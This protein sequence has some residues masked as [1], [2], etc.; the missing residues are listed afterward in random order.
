MS[1]TGIIA[2]FNPL[3]TGHKFLIDKAKQDGAVVCA[4][5]GNF[6][7]RGDT[8]IAEK[9][10]R[11]QAALLSGADLVLEIPVCYSMST[12][13]NFA[14]GGVSA[15]SAVGCD[16]LIFGSE[17]GEI[18]PL[19]AASDILETSEF[20]EKLQDYLKD[21]VTFA[22]ARQAAAEF[23]GAKSGILRGAN[24]NLAVE[25][26]SAAKK[27]GAEFEFKT[28]KRQGVLHDSD[29]ADENYASASLL[30]EKLRQGDRQFCLK[31]IPE[32]IIG[33]FGEENLS[34][35]KRIENAVLAVLKTKTPEE[36]KRLPDLSEGVENKLYT[37]IKRATSLE[38]LYSGIKVK[39]YTM[40][41]IRRLVLSAFLGVD[42]SFFMQSLP[43]VRVLGFNKTGEEI[44][45]QNAKNSK[46]PIVLRAGEI[47]SFGS[48]AQ[49]MFELESR[50]TDL[51]SLSLRKPIESGLEYTSKI[52]KDFY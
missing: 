11:A 13:Q 35:I 16:A 44:I 9:R 17:C 24:N 32:N 52:I 12:A 19:K 23:C 37:A 8:A 46:I 49:K 14:L 30:R 45:R 31:Y 7:Q 1:R 51:Y 48:S 25:Y 36:L 42:N 20:S 15:L 40:A 38:E 5:S 2:E 43:Y 18:A 3:H 4:V 39:R 29:E 26:I 6:V 33:L 47:S 27:I 21:G 34:D 28:V 10:V 22:K 50:A 41:R